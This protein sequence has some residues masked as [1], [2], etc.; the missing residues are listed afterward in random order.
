V[1]SGLYCE[2]VITSD[3]VLQVA[4]ALADPEWRENPDVALGM[5][6]YLGY[7]LHYPD[8]RTFGT[9]CVLDRQRHDYTD[10]IRR[11]VDRFRDLIEH[12]LALSHLN[13]VLSEE[14]RTLTDYIQEIKV[15]RGLV[16]ICAFCKNIRDHEGLWHPVEDYVTETTE[17]TF[18]H[19]YC[20]RCLHRNFPG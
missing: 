13:H 7:P 14:N 5:I 1:G 3:D 4:D 12:S 15:L 10:T 16:P 6:S 2:R 17:A 8:G 18:S 9:I 19:T 20:E 11:L